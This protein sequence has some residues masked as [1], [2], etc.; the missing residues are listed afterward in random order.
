MEVL[1]VGDDSADANCLWISH[2]LLHGAAQANSAHEGFHSV[3]WDS[4]LFY[5]ACDRVFNLSTYLTGI[6]RAAKQFLRGATVSCSR[7]MWYEARREVYLCGIGCCTR[8][9]LYEKT[10]SGNSCR[11]RHMFS[12]PS[13]VSKE[14]AA[15]NPRE[16]NGWFK[17][18]RLRERSYFQW[19]V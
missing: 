7:E 8:S 19:E 3:E 14:S 11:E 13:S 6:L 15:G 1:V 9:I 16:K 2:G 17:D 18:A 5:G 12:V 10:R 4:S